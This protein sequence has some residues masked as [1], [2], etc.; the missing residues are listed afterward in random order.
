MFRGVIKWHE[1]GGSS[2]KRAPLNNCLA[3]LVFSS[4]PICIPGPLWA[5]SWDPPRPRQLLQVARLASEFAQTCN[6]HP[7][8]VGTKSQAIVFV[9]S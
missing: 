9:D 4:F 5:F 8:W 2:Y 7:S 3:S 1:G 6:L